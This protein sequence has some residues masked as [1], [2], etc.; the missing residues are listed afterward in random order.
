MKQFYTPKRIIWTFATI[1][2]FCVAVPAKAAAPLSLADTS[3]VYTYD[4]AG[5]RIT[6]EVVYL[7]SVK[8][9]GSE[10]V[11]HQDQL[12]DTKITISPNPNGGKFTLKV[13]GIAGKINMKIYLYSISGALIYENQNP[14]MSTEIDISNRPNGMYVLSLIIENKRKTWSII[15]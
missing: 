6:R 14:E 13:T 1:I 11:V 12:G 15:R 5:N 3:V 7:K 9:V 4:Q 8:A 10:P 2:L